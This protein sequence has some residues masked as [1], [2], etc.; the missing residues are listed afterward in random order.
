MRMA[1][2]ALIRPAG[3]AGRSGRPFRTHFEKA[4]FIR[5]LQSL[6]AWTEHAQATLALL[7]DRFTRAELSDAI[8]ETR[9]QATVSGESEESND[10]L[11]A[12]TQ[13]NYRIP[14]SS[15]RRYL[16]GRHLPVFRQRTA[17]N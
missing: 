15:R 2:S 11:L 9:K 7:G 13:A 10:A 14:L 6:D 16:G 4:D 3:T 1:P 5:Q 12:L 8:D 17:R